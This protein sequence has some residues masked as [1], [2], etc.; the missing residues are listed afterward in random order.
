MSKIIAFF[1]QAGGVGKTSLV[2]HIGYMLACSK[3]LDPKTK[4]RSRKKGD[5]YRVLL[6]DMDPQ[7]SLTIFMGFDPYEMDRTIYH[8]I[9]HD[10]PLPIHKG[11]FAQNNS[12][13]NTEDKTPG[14]DLV[15]SNL[16]LA[17]AEREL[18][19]AVMS[20]FRLREALVPVKNQYDFILIDCPPSLG[21]LAYISL[22]AATHVL[23][24]IQAQ[25]KAFNGVQQ[26][27]DTITLVRSRPN[28]ELQIAGFVPTMYDQRNSHDERTLA[29]IHEQ[30]SVV[31]PVYPPIVRSTIF[32]DA[33]E[34]HLPLALYDKRHP[35]L[36]AMSQIINGLEL[37]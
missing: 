17:I 29:A 26:L 25:Y 3:R 11:V 24:P 5:F 32:A 27:F 14:V 35:A 36:Q 13:S 12:A 15:P 33:S 28:Q 4:R 8:A 9:L 22:V 20:D 18:M 31:A 10:E 16:G 34:E 37:L 30:L 7:A 1:N 23:V 19:S 21:N 2:N 6:I